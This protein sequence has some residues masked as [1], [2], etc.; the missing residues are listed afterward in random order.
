MFLKLPKG[1]SAPPERSGRFRRVQTDTSL[2]DRRN[3]RR[4]HPCL[5]PMPAV[6]LASPFLSHFHMEDGPMFDPYI[7]G[8]RNLHERKTGDLGAADRR[9][10]LVGGP[11]RDPPASA[12]RH[13]AGCRLLARRSRSQPAVAGAPDHQDDPAGGN[14]TGLA[15]PRRQDRRPSLS[16]KS[17]RHP[18]L[19]EAGP[20]TRVIR[21]SLV[22]GAT[23]SGSFARSHAA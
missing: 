14:R 9:D 15:A 6:E 12:S 11:C 5:W 8:S 20:A 19:R 7:P 3:A 23:Q 22:P 4:R 18:I 1:L 16:A 13:A 10:L 17:L 2:L 21:V